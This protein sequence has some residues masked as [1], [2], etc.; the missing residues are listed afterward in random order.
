MAKAD[1]LTLAF[2]GD[3]MIGRRVEAAL[4][5]RRPAE[6]WGEFLPT[7][8]GADLVIGNLECPITEATTRWPH[9][10][11][12]RFKAS[13]RALDILKAG[14]VGAVNLANNHIGDYCE[15]GVLDSLAALEKAGI[16]AFGAGRDLAAARQPA[17][18]ERQG[19]RLGIVGLSDRMPEFGAS[20]SQPGHNFA[21]PPKGEP[22]ASRVMSCFAAGDF[23][24]RLLDTHWGPD[25][26]TRP[27]AARR[28]F[29][30]AL[31]RLGADIIHGHSSH[32]T[33]GVEVIEGRPVMY[34]NGNCLEDF[35]P[36]P[37]VWTKRSSV[38]VLELGRQGSLLRQLPA[39]TLGMQLSRPKGALLAA[40]Q[41]RFATRSR[42]LGSALQLVDDELHLPLELRL[43]S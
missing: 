3:M 18:I 4:G 20:D 32:I 9:P 26:M 27:T 14:N 41:R 37:W 22:E 21:W 2:V 29:A 35:W 7:L 34:D 6:Y 5:H 13:E 39:L 1:R 11:T 24:L 38:F 36:Y 10:K 19:W 12:W 25:L 33:H 8:Q 31:V 17:R 43:P 40:M 30:S 42:A 16:V 15:A 23:D 28:R